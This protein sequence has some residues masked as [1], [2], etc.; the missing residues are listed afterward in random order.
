[1][2]RASLTR[3]AWL[4]VGAAIATIGLK[5]AA[6]W[7]TGSVGL[8]S[9]AIESLVNLAAALLALALLTVAARPPDEEHVYGHGKAEYFASGAEG[10]MILLAAASIAYTAIDRLFNPQTLEQTGL[11]LAMSAV[12]SVINLAVARVLLKAG[13]DFNSITLEA[14][15]RHLLTDVWTSL[16]VIVGVGLVALTGW[17]ALDPI[18]ALAVALNIVWSGY[19]LLR[20]SVQGL[21]DTALPADERAAVVQVLDQFVASEGIGYHALRT[22]QAGARRFVSCHILVPGSWSVQHGHHLLEQIEAGIRSRL[23]DVTVF[24]HLEPRDDPRSFDDMQLDRASGRPDAAPE[25]P[26]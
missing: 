8:L 12:A 19:G 6:Y 2:D 21:M 23:T 16:G 4:S 17:A 20:R 18:L 14:D 22:R 26:Q 11:G 7:L 25:L 3:F 9:D 10:T 15:A 5:S 24:T 1:M 13:R